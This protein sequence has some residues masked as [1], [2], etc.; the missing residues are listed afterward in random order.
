MRGTHRPAA[1][2]EFGYAAE[3]GAEFVH[4]AAPMTRALMREAGLSLAPMGGAR[5]TARTAS[6]RRTSLRRH[7]RVSC[8]AP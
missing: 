4:G 1:G 6:Y 8:I 2:Q 3:G 5:W 7:M